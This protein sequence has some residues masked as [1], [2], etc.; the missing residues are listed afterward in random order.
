M[1]GL[2]TAVIVHHFENS[3]K[4]FK[5]GSTITSKLPRDTTPSA[6]RTGACVKNITEMAT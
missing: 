4:P 1:G 3:Y 2:S 5:I 6:A